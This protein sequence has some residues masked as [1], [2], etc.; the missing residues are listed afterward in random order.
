M[1]YDL[2]VGADGVGSTVRAQM[3]QQLPGMSGQ[4]SAVLA[5]T[6]SCTCNL[7]S[8]LAALAVSVT[9]C[10]H[11]LGTHSMCGQ[12]PQPVAGRMLAPVIQLTLAQNIS[13][14]QTSSSASA[15]HL[16]KVCNKHE[17]RAVPQAGHSDAK[18]L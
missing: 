15:K 1:K 6:I 13:T 18:V 11:H 16:L 12:D 17:H 7:L 5:C 2:L 4:C 8:W 10:Q 9:H 14:L 3:E